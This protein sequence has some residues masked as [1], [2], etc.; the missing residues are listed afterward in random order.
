M[1]FLFCQQDD[2]IGTKGEKKWHE[3]QENKF[4]V[5]KKGTSLYVSREIYSLIFWEDTYEH[6]DFWYSEM[7]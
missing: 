5:D 1:T 3:W 6:S 4:E 2:I 7:F